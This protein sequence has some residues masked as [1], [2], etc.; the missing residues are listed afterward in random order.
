MSDL[1]SSLDE[2]STVEEIKIISKVKAVVD[3][4]KLFTLCKAGEL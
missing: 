2:D 1:I 3:R 4:Q